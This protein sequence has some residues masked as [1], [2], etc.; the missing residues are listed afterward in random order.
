MAQEARLVKCN[1]CH[2]VL[3]RVKETLNAGILERLKRHNSSI[4]RSAN[5]DRGG[6]FDIGSVCKD[7][8]NL[9]KTLGSVL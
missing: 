4:G 9:E 3:V 7:I 6:A 5:G 1:K 2:T 8:E